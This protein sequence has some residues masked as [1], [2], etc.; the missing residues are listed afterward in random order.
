MEGVVGKTVGM[1]GSAPGSAG[2]QA[3]DGSDARRRGAAALANPAQEHK[4]ALPQRASGRRGRQRRWQPGL[5]LEGVRLGGWR[6]KVC[7]DAYH[8]A[9]SCSELLGSRLAGH[10]AELEGSGALGAP[11]QGCEWQVGLGS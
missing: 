9:T 11:G 10:G 4:Q 3:W 1:G 7:C 5:T 6:H 2:L 8:L